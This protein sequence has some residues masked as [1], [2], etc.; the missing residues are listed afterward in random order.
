MVTGRYFATLWEVGLIH[1]EPPLQ[2]VACFLFYTVSNRVFIAK[3]R[4]MKVI[5]NFRGT[6]IIHLIKSGFQ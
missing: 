4:I 6:P 5:N 1:S 3:S 2:Y